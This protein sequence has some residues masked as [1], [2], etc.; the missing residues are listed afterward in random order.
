MPDSPGP[1]PTE[2]PWAIEAT[3]SRRS[4]MASVRPEVLITKVPPHADDEEAD[5]EGSGGKK[6]KMSMERLMTLLPVISS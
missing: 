5:S 1:P 6:E 4:S 2:N 3:T